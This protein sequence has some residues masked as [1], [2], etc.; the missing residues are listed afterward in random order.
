MPSASGRLLHGCDAA[1]VARGRAREDLLHAGLAGCRRDGLGLGEGLGAAAVAAAAHRSV[2]EHGLVADLAPGPGA[3]VKLAVDDQPAADPRP[4][5]HE[6]H[7]PG[8]PAG[9]H[10]R[11]REGVRPGVVDEHDRPAEAGLEAGLERIAGPRPR[12]VREEAD[13]A[14]LALEQAG[15]ADADRGDR[16]VHRDRVQA[17]LDHDR[18]D[19]VRSAFGVGRDGV[20]RE[21]SRDGA[22]RVGPLEDRD[23]EVGPA[24]VEAE[25]ATRRHDTSAWSPRWSTASNS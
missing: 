5:G 14:G 17:G 6:R 15:D 22:V 2:L 24:E 16:P 3:E 19:A 7:R 8:A 13:D 20:A 10:P 11:L 9:A 1:L 25:V 18:D 23:L 21:E 4:E 12:E